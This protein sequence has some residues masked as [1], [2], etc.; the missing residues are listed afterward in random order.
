I[1][2]G[3]LSLAGLTTGE[4]SPFRGIAERIM[5][6]LP[7][8]EESNTYI[9]TF[10]SQAKIQASSA[11]CE[12][13]IRAARGDRTLVTILCEKCAQR[14]SEKMSKRLS[15]PMVEEAIQE[16][17]LDQAHSHAPLQ[18][19]L[20][21]IESDPDLLTCTL[22][23][24]KKGI[25]HRGQLPLPLSPDIDPFCLTGV[26]RKVEPD[27]Y[28]FRNE[29][30]R[31]FLTQYFNP[32][33]VGHILTMSGR[34]G[35]A[36]E[37]LE[38]SVKKG[39]LQYRSDLFAATIHSM[40]ASQ[41]IEQ[42]AEYLARGLSA[43][44]KTKICCVW[45]FTPGRKALKFIGGLGKTGKDRL[46]IGLEI[47]ISDERLE[48]RAYRDICTLRGMENNGN[49]EWA[50]PLSISD[51]LP[52]GVVYAVIH[53]PDWEFDRQRE[54][55]LELTGYLHQAARALQEVETRQNW[56]KQL[57]TLDQ[58]ALSISRQLEIKNILQIAV[59]KAT[60]LVGGMGGGIYLWDE[61][62]KTFTL[63]TLHGLPTS[64]VGEKYPQ[65][66]G[67]IGEIRITKQPFSI[68]N[69]YRWAKRQQAF[70]EYRITAVVGAPILSGDRLVGVIAIHDER[71]ER[72]FQKEDEELLLRVGNHVAAALEH[73]RAYRLQQEANDYRERLIS[74]SLDGIIAVDKE[75]CVTVYNEGA[76]RICGYARDE[77]IGQWVDKLYGNLEIPRSINRELF[78]QEKLDNYETTLC[79]K[80]GQR[81]PIFLSAAL[82]RDQNGEPTGSVGFF[83][84][85]RP[86]RTIVDT[87]Y[88]VARARDLNEG[89]NALARG[90]VKGMNVT[91]CH[92]LLMDENSRFLEVKEAHSPRGKNLKWKP[93]KGKRLDL[94]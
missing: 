72:D 85:L 12:F 48:A 71:E 38:A 83:K 16:F 55:E 62:S 36:I 66:Q 92:I 39:D 75:G 57:G 94:E 73:A 43:G 28:Q 77:V 51:R 14:V 5:V 26:I 81:I 64:L 35:Q 69:Y 49:V 22:L 27:S 6:D 1:V 21:L 31:Q 4:T 29:I 60:E 61:I 17:I 74:S 79:S 80:D 89:L 84:D 13:L 10:F 67:V 50:I 7:P 91:F 45:Y 25:V 15:V 86:L 88:A 47:P 65:D 87:V 11:A 2:A 42:A 40:Y 44:F 20:R 3:S 68:S 78:K 70:D 30:F 33:R 23:L 18:E 82:I 52:I 76:E 9:T 56:Q 8:D 41:N 34:W 24:A 90:L 19:A 32:G 63:E 37:Y 59:E 93:N 54:W 58:I 53:M 46:A